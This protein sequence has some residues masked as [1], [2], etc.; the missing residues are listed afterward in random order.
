VKPL[1]CASGFFI[2]LL[3]L[4]IP[5]MYIGVKYFL[6]PKYMTK[7]M[8]RPKLPKGQSKDFQIGVRFNRD[9]AGKI[10]TV[11]AKTGLTNADWARSVLVGA[12]SA[13]YNEAQS[14]RRPNSS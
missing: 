9:E 7:K 4:L 5:E 2:Y 8:G 13:N 12:A 1:V 3:D 11:V 14:S 10:R 6:I